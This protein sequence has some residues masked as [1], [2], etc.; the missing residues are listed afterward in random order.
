ML[1]PL[2]DTCVVLCHIDTT[3]HIWTVYLQVPIINKQKHV[4]QVLV[5]WM[6][7]SFVHYFFNFSALCKNE[8]WNIEN[9]AIKVYETLKN[10]NHQHQI[11]L[12]ILISPDEM[13][14]CLSNF[15][16]EQK[17]FKSMGKILQ[18]FQVTAYHN[19]RQKTFYILVQYET[20]LFL[21]G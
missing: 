14:L 21:L 5:F 4:D 15:Y 2:Q 10:T 19:F 13:G 9:D 7:L 6:I 1:C 12:D 17:Y 16:K 11:V 3:Q 18:Q 20:R 8:I